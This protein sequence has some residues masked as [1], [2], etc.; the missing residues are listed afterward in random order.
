MPSISLIKPEIQEVVLP[1]FSN[2]GVNLKILRLDQMHKD[3]GGNKWFK[4]K[5]SIEEI[6]SLQDCVVLSFG[7]PYSNHLRALSAAGKC[8]SFKTIGIVRG[9]IVR[10]LNPVLEFAETNGMSLYGVSRHDYRLKNSEKFV[11]ELRDRF[12]NFVLLP[13]GGSTQKALL[14][15]KEI[16]GF[17]DPKAKARF[18]YIALACG[19]GITLA[20]IALGANSFQNTKILG[21][22]ILNAPG[23]LSGQIQTFVHDHQQ[24]V[25]NSEFAAWSM[26][27]NYHFG[28][29]AKSSPDLLKFSE[30]FTDSTG[31]PLEPVY[32]GKLFYALAK[33][34]ER[35]SISSG[36]EILA[37]HTGGIY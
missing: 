11:S 14:G 4:L 2:Y 13:E 21:V 27:E 7:G 28:G 37:I 24:N 34:V 10:P 6:S 32:T 36:D 29:Y 17:I 16:C 33:E 31:V 20:G 25:L 3:L 12:G 8:F 35:G 5:Y 1:E 30:G 22:S 9:E 15:C 18:R 19:T 26:L 23:Y